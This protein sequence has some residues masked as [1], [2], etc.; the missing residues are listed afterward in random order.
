MP[1]ELNDRNGARYTLS[2]RDPCL[3]KTYLTRI[4]VKDDSGTD[5]A[6]LKFGDQDGSMFLD[7]LH[8]FAGH[9]RKGIGSALLALVEDQA[10][11]RGLRYVRGI[12]ISH[13]S[14]CDERNSLLDWYRRRG[15]VVTGTATPITTVVSRWSL[16]RVSACCRQQQKL[17]AFS[18]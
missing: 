9:R 15:Y 3:T 14:S 7:D 1:T 4:L 6:E 11:A 13:D 18:R 8:V 12:A 5:I 2:I 17:R 10:L 16:I